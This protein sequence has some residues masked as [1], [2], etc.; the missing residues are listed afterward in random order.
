MQIAGSGHVTRA[1]RHAYH[2]PAQ[3]LLGANPFEGEV[4]NLSASG[5]AVRLGDGGIVVDNGT[6]VDMHVEGLGRVRGNVARTY[7]GGFGLKFDD[8]GT[9]MAAVAQSLRH[10]NRLA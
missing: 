2:R 7:E 6:F 5:A 4:E 1:P 3:G 10:Y 8:R 9:D